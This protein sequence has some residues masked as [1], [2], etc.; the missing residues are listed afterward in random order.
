[1]KKKF[2]S[3]VSIGAIFKKQRMLKRP[4]YEVKLKPPSKK[5]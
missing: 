1:M 3:V 5:V 2:A 4:P